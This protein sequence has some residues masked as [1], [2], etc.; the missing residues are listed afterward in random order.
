MSRIAPLPW[1]L[2]VLY[3][4]PP[5]LT[6]VEL[7]K[8]VYSV[9]LAAFFVLWLYTMAGGIRGL[10]HPAEKAGASSLSD[11]RAGLIL[12]ASLIVCLVWIYFSGIGGFAFCRWDYVKHIFI[13]TELLEDRLPVV[14]DRSDDTPDF[15]LHYPFSYYLLPVRLSQMAEAMHLPVDLNWLLLFYYSGLAFAALRLMAT[16]A[17]ISTLALVAFVIASGGLD[18]LG[19]ALFGV[20]VETAA[21]DGVQVPWNLEWWGFPFA[22][23][24]L[25]ANLYWAPQHFFAALLG[26]AL[27]LH[28]PGT[29]RLAATVLADL[30]IVVCAGALWSPYVAVGLASLAACRILIVDKAALLQRMRREQMDKRILEMAAALVFAAALATFAA[31]F[32]LAAKP[33]SVPLFAWNVGHAG[34]WMV[35]LI[36]NYAPFLIAVALLIALPILAL[37]H[38]NPERQETRRMLLRTFG[39]FLVASAILLMVAHGAYNDWA[40]RT[41]LPLWI[42]LCV[43]ALRFLSMPIGWMPRAAL[44]GVLVIASADSMSEIAQSVL[45]E[46]GCAP[47]GSYDLQ[48]LGEIAPQYQG[49]PDSVLYRRLARGS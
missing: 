29:S 39:A 7:L 1:T 30:A 44:I 45:D 43:A 8:P 21:F 10:A 11:L 47:Y 26:T 19:M 24:S 32:F 12:R 46:R 13:F 37:R 35:T 41:L 14:I 18:L 33:L 5:V 2:A 6:A 36:V 20:K 27:V 9:P 42:G 28:L 49:L 23:Q 16:D 25:T 3:T 34:A 38:G 40:M 15:I 17:K 48:A 31:I 4:L 22:P